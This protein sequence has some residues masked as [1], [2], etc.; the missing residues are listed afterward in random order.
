MVDNNTVSVLEKIDKTQE[1]VLKE[2]VIKEDKQK[3]TPVRAKVEKTVEK[4]AA[5]VEKTV[6]EAAE[7]VEKTVEQATET[8]EKTVETNLERVEKVIDDGLHKVEKMA[9]SVFDETKTAFTTGYLKPARPAYLAFLG[10][11]KMSA[12][13]IENWWKKLLEKGEVVEKEGIHLFKRQYHP[14]VKA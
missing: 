7:T 10:M 3:M 13:T 12:D 1:K 6:E 2:K 9:E 14:D 5:K 8:V 4:S 11:V